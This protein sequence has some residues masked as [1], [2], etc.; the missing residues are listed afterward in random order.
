MRKLQITSKLFLENHVTEQVNNFNFLG[1]YNPY[2]VE[3]KVNRKLGR[4][5][6]MCALKRK[7]GWILRRAFIKLCQQGLIYMVVI[8]GP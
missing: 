5:K 6:Y 1:C 4:F 8:Y 2:L 3:V 7:E